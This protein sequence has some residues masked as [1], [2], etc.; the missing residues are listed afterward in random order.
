MKYTIFG[1]T[2]LSVS[3]IAVGGYPF[4]GVNKA[5]GWDP[6]S[7]Q[8][9]KDAIRVVH[10]ALDAGINYVDT[11]PS[12]GQ[13]HSESII[14]EA[15][16]GKREKVILA[17]KVTWTTSWAEIGKEGVIRGVEES[18]RRLKTDYVDVIQLHGGIYSHKDTRDVL[19]AGPM[20]ALH[21]LR[22]QGKV[23]FLGLTTEDA[24]SILELIDTNLFDI[25]QINYNLIYQNAALRFLDRAK[26]K[27]LGVAV[28]RPMTSGIFQ[29]L[30]EHLAPRLLETEDIYRLCLKF[31]LSDSRIH[32]LNIG[33]RWPEE[34]ERNI[35]FLDEFTPDFDIADLP[36]LTAKIYESDDKRNGLA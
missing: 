34:V 23:K 1:K 16:Q 35:R 11:A 29:R 7:P 6:Y 2:G 14:G 18:L 25:A 10:A 8:G 5:Q 3:R 28:M 24:C 19:S 13:G 22:E 4:A 27:N 33:A 9:R 30:L 12:Y 17:T 21:L 20:E 36:R 15:L 31:L 32:M 26:E